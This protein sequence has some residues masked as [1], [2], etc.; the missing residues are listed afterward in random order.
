MDGIFLFIVLVGALV[1]FD[2]G[3]LRFGAEAPGGPTDSRTSA[4]NVTT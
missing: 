1:A 2:L 4:R 3:A